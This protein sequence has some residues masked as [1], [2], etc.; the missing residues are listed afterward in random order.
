[1]EKADKDYEASLLSRLEQPL[2]KLPFKS[3]YQV[4]FRLQDRRRGR[5]GLAV[6]RFLR[7]TGFVHS[8]DHVEDTPLGKAVEARPLSTAPPAGYFAAVGSLAVEA[9]RDWSQ[10]GEIAERARLRQLIRNPKTSGLAEQIADLILEASTHY[11]PV[12]PLGKYLPLNVLMICNPTDP[13]PKAAVYLSAAY[14]VHFGFLRGCNRCEALY[15]A[16]PPTRRCC[17]TCYWIRVKMPTAKWRVWKQIKDRL[18]KR[19]PNRTERER[20]LRQA[21]QDLLGMTLEKWQAKWDQRRGPQGRKGGK[22][23]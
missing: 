3:Q 9:D 13:Y 8:P 21:E 23:A 4:V 7:E 16:D 14:G 19:Y 22:Q 18:R 10:A 20:E 1:M 6:E 2:A 17:D 11:L 12:Y 15:I 5:Q